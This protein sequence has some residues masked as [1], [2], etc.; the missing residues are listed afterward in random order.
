METFDKIGALCDLKD[1]KAVFDHHGVPLL[2]SYGVLLGWVRDKDFIP[3]DDDMDFVV[4]EPITFEQRKKLGWALYDLGFQPQKISFRVFGRFE[5]SETGYNG[6]EHSGIIVCKRNVPVTIF[7]FGDD[8]K[9]LVC[10]PKMGSPIMIATPKQFY[11]TY[12]TIK[13]KG[14]TYQTPSPIKGYLEST[15]GKDWKTPKKNAHA[16]QYHQ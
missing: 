2:V 8:G 3:W 15:Y 10:R 7:F 1:I 12:D 6:D 16:K 9:E 13:F 5:A 4:T 11:E 14:V